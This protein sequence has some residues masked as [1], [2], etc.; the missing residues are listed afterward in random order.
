MFIQILLNSI[1]IRTKTKK[2]HTF[3]YTRLLTHNQSNK[4]HTLLHHVQF[5][6]A[7]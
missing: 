6:E 5:E 4:L 1:S 2:N 3:T 7:I